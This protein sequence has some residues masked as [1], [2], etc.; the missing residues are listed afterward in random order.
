VLV[1]WRNSAERKKRRLDTGR[2]GAA[3]P[4]HPRAI[5]TKPAE[6]PPEK[7]A[8]SGSET[9]ASETGVSA[10]TEARDESEE[11]KNTFRRLSREARKRK[12]K[13]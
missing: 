3:H 1:G 8:A 9:A 6:D 4:N 10:D 12:A 2:T 7:A 5:E 11:R 13:K